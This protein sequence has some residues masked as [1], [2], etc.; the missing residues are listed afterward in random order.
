M[1]YTCGKAFL[2]FSQARSEALNYYKGMN[3]VHG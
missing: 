2:N 3:Y 1:F